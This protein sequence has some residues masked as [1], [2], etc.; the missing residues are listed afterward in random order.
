MTFWTP[1]ITISV[2]KK[3]YFYFDEVTNFSYKGKYKWCH[4]ICARQDTSLILNPLGHLVLPT[5]MARNNDDN[6]VI[7]ATGKPT[8][9]C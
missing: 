3:F 6:T 1:H 4:K 8:D 5:T 2:E 7:I 9:V